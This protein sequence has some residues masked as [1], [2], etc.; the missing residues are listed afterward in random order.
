MRKLE[1]S[2][3]DRTNFA[4]VLTALG[5]IAVL[6]TCGSCAAG[7]LPA[8]A[9][10][11]EQQYESSVQITTICMTSGTDGGMSMT[12]ATGSGTLLSAH[13]VL[14][15][16]H[17]MQCD[18]GLGL[19]SVDVGDGKSHSAETDVLLPKADIARA[20]VD[21]DLSKWFTPVSFGPAPKI[22][23]RVCAMATA[24]FTV[25]RCYTAQLRGCRREWRHSSGRPD[26]VR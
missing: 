4:L 6:A 19:T 5:L 22:G 16:A 13:E 10:S 9:R 21:D 25:Y 8:A 20:H 14:T 12:V 26:R 23:D 7:I 3:A 15:A 18:G 1:L 2:R 17:V 24:P 11:P